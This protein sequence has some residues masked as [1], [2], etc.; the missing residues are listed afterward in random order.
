M[1]EFNVRIRLHI[2]IQVDRNGF[3]RVTGSGNKDGAEDI[4]AQSSITESSQSR[5]RT[6]GT[7]NNEGQECDG[8][9]DQPLLR[10]V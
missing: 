8:G 10:M 3:A 2:T 1:I 5:T 7:Q 9:D 6:K 4:S